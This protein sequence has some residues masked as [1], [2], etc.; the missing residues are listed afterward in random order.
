MIGAIL[1]FKKDWIT[2]LGF[3]NRLSQIIA[4]VIAGILAFVAFNVFISSVLSNGGYQM[5]SAM[6]RLSEY[7]GSYPLLCRTLWRICQPLNEEIVL[8]ALLLGFFAHFFSNRACLAIIAALVFSGLHLL[9]YYFGQLN[10]QLDISALLTLFFFALAANS[11]Y[12]AFNHIAFGFVFHLAWNWWRFSGDIVRDGVVLNEAQTFNAL[13]GSTTVL[14]F[15]SL[16]SLACFI[17]LGLRTSK[18]PLFNRQK[19]PM[20]YSSGNS[21][22]S[23]F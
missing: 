3:P 17:G 1:F 2:I 9:I 13:E 22:E 4:C 6:G 15:V 8:R 11:L 12:L 14:I 18:I 20:K 23:R 21:A 7:F 10:T 19:S 5:V 16:L